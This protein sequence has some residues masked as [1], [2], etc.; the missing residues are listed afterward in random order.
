MVKK[1]KNYYL[2][3]VQLLFNCT[4][5]NFKLDIFHNSQIRLIL[6]R[7]DSLGWLMIPKFLQFT[8]WYIS[9]WYLSLC[10]IC[11]YDHL[12]YDMIL[13]V[14]HWPYISYFNFNYQFLWLILYVI[15]LLAF[16]LITLHIILFT[17]SILSI[18]HSTDR[19]LL[20]ILFYNKGAHPTSNS[21][22]ILLWPC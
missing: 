9:Q 8:W 12:V 1:L 10:K 20:Y 15:V 19:I 2:L 6:D 5:F 14:M 18:F 21:W 4:T 11:D 3:V 22:L 7:I 16:K 17:Y 13:R